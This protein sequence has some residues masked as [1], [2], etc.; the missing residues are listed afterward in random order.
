MPQIMPRLDVTMVEISRA[1][2]SFSVRGS[3]LAGIFKK[4]VGELTMTAKA[5]MMLLM[6]WF[7]ALLLLS[8]LLVR[9]AGIGDDGDRDAKRI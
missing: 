8:Q 7:S 3:P 4:A 1:Q 2:W 6:L 9:L 5:L